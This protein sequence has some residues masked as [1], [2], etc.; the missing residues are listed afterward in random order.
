MGKISVS[1]PLLVVYAVAVRRVPTWGWWI[2]G[3]AAAS[4]VGYLIL[5]PS[6][7]T[8]GTPPGNGAHPPPL[9]PLPEA[10]VLDDL[11]AVAIGDAPGWMRMTSV[12]EPSEQVSE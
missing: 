6:P 10:D 2:L 12:V 3:I 4:G 7:S 11:N 9:P 8:A 5:R 1:G